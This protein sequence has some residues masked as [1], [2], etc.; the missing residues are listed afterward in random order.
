MDA[1]RPINSIVFNTPALS[2]TATVSEN[3]NYFI[4]SAAQSIVA[5]GATLGNCPA[6]IV[7]NTGTSNS[8]VINL[9]TSSSLRI[10]EVEL[11]N[12][13]SVKQ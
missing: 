12:I 11:V 13:I 10:T 3:T 9:A 2:H 1:I 4:P 6:G 7:V 8:L 5:N